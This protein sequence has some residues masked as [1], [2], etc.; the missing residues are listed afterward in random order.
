MHPLC[1]PLLL[2]ALSSPQR[3]DDFTLRD[4]RGQ[5]HRLSDW[6]EKKLLVVVFLGVDCPLAKLYGPRL[7]EMARAYEDR[8]V[9]VL[10]IHA[11][12][13]E[14]SADL[15]RYAREHHIAFPLLRD[16]GNTVADRFGAPRTPDACILDRQ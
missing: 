15:V 9:T 6:S 13:H 2:T 8:G 7:A 11:N 12:A 10:G 4:Y 5:T 14:S 3:I 1:L 16:S